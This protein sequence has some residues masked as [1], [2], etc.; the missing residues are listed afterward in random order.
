MYDNP[1]KLLSAIAESVDGAYDEEAWI[2]FT[3]DVA[4][5]ASGY[6]IYNMWQAWQRHGTLPRMGGWLDQ[7][8]RI[9]LQILAIDTVFQTWQARRRKDG[10]LLLEQMNA[11][12]RAITLALD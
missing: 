9:M 5:V 1:K 2:K 8:L 10:G 12:Q 11:T 6:A 3:E 7:P 4:T